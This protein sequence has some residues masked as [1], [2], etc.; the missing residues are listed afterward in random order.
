MKTA[1]AALALTALLL[2]AAA[3]RAADSF[4]IERLERSCALQRESLLRER[5]GTPA[6]DA[7]KRAKTAKAKRQAEAS[8]RPSEKSRRGGSRKKAR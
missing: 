4:E 5:N 6:C 7:L 3:A 2:P 1:L 8:D